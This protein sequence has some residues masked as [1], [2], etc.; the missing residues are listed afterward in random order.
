MRRGIR[1]LVALLLLVALGVFLP[2]FGL[3][4]LVALALDRLVL[5]RVPALASWFGVT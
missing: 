5:R 4:L 1:S 3:S 2:Y